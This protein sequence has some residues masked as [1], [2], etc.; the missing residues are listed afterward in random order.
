MHRLVMKVLAVQSKP[1][2]VRKQF[3]KLKAALKDELGIEPAVET[4]RLYQGTSWKLN[5]C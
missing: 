4:S 3:E 1:A 2:A 5:Y